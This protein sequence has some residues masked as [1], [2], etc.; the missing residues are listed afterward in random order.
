MVQKIVT[1]PAIEALLRQSEAARR[2]L[3]YDIAA[4]RH[5]VDVPARLKESLQLHP[6]G[7]IG[8][9]LAAGLLTSMAFRRRKAKPAV[10]TEEKVRRAGLTGL[11]LTAG[12][13]L[14]KPMVKSLVAGYLRKKLSAHLAPDH[15][16]HER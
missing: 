9:S 15:H 2:R 7:W 8:G 11:A 10:A 16:P 12:G 4:L 1:D 6:T 13:A 3:A 5:Q 14:L